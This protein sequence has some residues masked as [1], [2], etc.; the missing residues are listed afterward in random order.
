VTSDIRSEEALSSSAVSCDGPSAQP[1]GGR[2]ETRIPFRPSPH[3]L[4]N[5][6]ARALWGSVWLFLFRP[7]PRIFHGWRTILLRLFGARIGEGAVV[8]ASVR[9][10]APWNLELGPHSCLSPQVDCYSVDAVR[11]GA[12]ATISQYSFLCAASHDPDSPDMTLTT[13]PIII[14]DHVWVAADV[15]I[16]PGVIVGEGAVIGARS[17][18]FK[19]VPAWTIVAGSPARI[20]R[21]RARAV[22]DAIHRPGGG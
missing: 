19:D 13:S 9:V 11:I 8:H 16:A 17:S 3:P 15:F 1:A 10:W 18:V 12:Y 7:S 5:R 2:A 6:L 4:S 22:A 14:G 21:K 20:I